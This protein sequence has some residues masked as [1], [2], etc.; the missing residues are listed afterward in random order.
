M[1]AQ[2]LSAIGSVE[3]EERRTVDQRDVL[4]VDC[5]AKAG[6]GRVADAG[7]PLRFSRLGIHHMHNACRGQ[8][9]EQIA[10]QRDTLDAMPGWVHLH[11]RKPLA[12]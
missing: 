5:R 6:I 9:N 11:L 1:L 8:G 12:L 7:D 4:S 2:N 10:T 3:H